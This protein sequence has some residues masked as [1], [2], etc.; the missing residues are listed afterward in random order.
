MLDDI[1]ARWVAKRSHCAPWTRLNRERPF[2]TRPRR[3]WTG[4]T[5]E[6][7]RRKSRGDGHPSATDQAPKRS[8]QNR[9]G[10]QRAAAGRGP[11]VAPKANAAKAKTPTPRRCRRSR[12]TVTTAGSDSEKTVDRRG[13]EGE[14][15]QRQN[16]N[17]TTTSSKPVHRDDGRLRPEKR[18]NAARRG[19]L[20]TP[21]ANAPK[22]ASS[23]PI[24]RP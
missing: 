11:L 16:A 2:P 22:A 17:P 10:F 4:K 23:T 12:S 3:A 5:P 24:D 21:K 18:S 14:C 13:T 20:I 7:R 15:T 6:R 9:A 19:P 8:K 1:V